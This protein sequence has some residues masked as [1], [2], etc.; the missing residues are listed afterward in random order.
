MTFFL[1]ITAL[2]VFVALFA[3]GLP[4]QDPELPDCTAISI[5]FISSIDAVN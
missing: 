2:C 5:L 1:Q 4:A 3:L